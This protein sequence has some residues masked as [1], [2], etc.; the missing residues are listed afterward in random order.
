MSAPGSL[1]GGNDP[2]PYVGSGP[3]SGVSDPPVPAAIAEADGWELVETVDETLEDYPVVTIHL[4]RAL[5]GDR[6]LRDCVDEATGHD[7]L[8]RSF[9]ASRLTTTPELSPRIAGLVLDTIAVPTAKQRLVEDLE[10][11]GFRSVR[12]RDSR[13]LT[14][15]ADERARATEFAT[16]IPLE[17]PAGADADRRNDDAGTDGPDA[18]E[19]RTAAWLAVWKRGKAILVGGGIYPVEPPAGADDCFEGADHYRRKLV[20]LI[21]SIE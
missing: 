9:F 3:T 13:R 20:D 2:N 12:E 19:V 8:W 16:A 14:V 7:R 1:P 21:R 11:Q 4:R 15:R 17:P 18:G 5:Y 10:S 6:R